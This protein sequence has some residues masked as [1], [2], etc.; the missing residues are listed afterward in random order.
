MS[1]QSSPLDLTGNTCEPT[2]GAAAEQ[3][4]YPLQWGGR[5]HKGRQVQV[6]SARTEMRCAAVIGGKSG[7]GKCLG[8]EV[9]ADETKSLLK[10][11]LRGVLRSS[12]F[13]AHGHGSEQVHTMLRLL[14]CQCTGPLSTLQPLVA[15]AT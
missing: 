1:S 13:G 7:E 14:N 5:F 9:E 11:D 2:V 3:A 15:R 8:L 4:Q 6:L 12:G 10:A